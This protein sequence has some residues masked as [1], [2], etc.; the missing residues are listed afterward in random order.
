MLSC[1]ECDAIDVPVFFV[2]EEPIVGAFC[3]HSCVHDRRARL[4]QAQSQAKEVE[5]EDS[6]YATGD[7]EDRSTSS[8]DRSLEKEDDETPASPAVTAADPGLEQQQQQRTKK[9]LRAVAPEERPRAGRSRRNRSAPAKTYKALGLWWSDYGPC[10]AT[11]SEIRSRHAAQFERDPS[12]IDTTAQYYEQ[13]DQLTM[14]NAITAEQK[15]TVS[16]WFA[17]STTSHNFTIKAGN[18]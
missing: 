17:R 1:R 12:W 15:S 18:K 7:E 13:A 16:Q 4:A 3:S 9:R 11:I 14:W 6:G 10:V 2:H 8:L 5:Q